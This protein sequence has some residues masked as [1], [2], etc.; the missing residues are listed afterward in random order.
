LVFNEQNN[1]QAPS[2]GVG[3][4]RDYAHARLRVNQWPTTSLCVSIDQFVK[5]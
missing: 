3:G 5:N 1:V 2:N 4:L